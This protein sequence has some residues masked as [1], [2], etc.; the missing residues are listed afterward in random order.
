MSDEQKPGKPGP[1]KVM[2]LGT[3][4]TLTRIRRPTSGIIPV[5]RTP[6]WLKK[7]APE[8]EKSEGDQE[9]ESG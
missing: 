1:R 3:E 9:C 6:P 8:S 7:P 4:Y 2:I 5:G